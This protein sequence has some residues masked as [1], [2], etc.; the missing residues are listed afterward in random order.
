MNECISWLDD[1]GFQVHNF[2]YQDRIVAWLKQSFLAH[3][4]ISGRDLLIVAQASQVS[5]VAFAKLF[6]LI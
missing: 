1:L 5:I 4:P 6:I 3:F 2:V